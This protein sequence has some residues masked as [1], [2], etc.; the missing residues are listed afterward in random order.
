M[1]VV[2]VVMGGGGGMCVQA[3]KRCRVLLRDNKSPMVCYAKGCDP[4]LRLQS[5]KATRNVK[6]V[7]LVRR[8]CVEARWCEAPTDETVHAVHAVH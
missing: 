1:V 5:G 4:H 3:V 7:A 8:Q 6:S 2:V